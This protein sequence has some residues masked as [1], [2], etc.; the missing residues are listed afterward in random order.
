MAAPFEDARG[1]LGMVLELAQH[2]DEFI[3]VVDS[4]WIDGVLPRRD[5]RCSFGIGWDVFSILPQDA[6]RHET[7]T[8]AISNMTLPGFRNFRLKTSINIGFGSSCR[9]EVLDAWLKFLLIQTNHCNVS[10]SEMNV[11]LKVA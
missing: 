4:A 8:K 2:Y 5:D 7:Q 11:Q 3:Q 10:D 6:G 9:L 1:F